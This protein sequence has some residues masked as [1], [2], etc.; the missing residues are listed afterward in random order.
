MPLIAFGWFS[1]P[2]VA[3]HVSRVDF[4]YDLS[5]CRTKTFAGETHYQAVQY[6]GR[7]A[8]QADSMASASGLVRRLDIDLRETPYLNGSWA[9]DRPFSNANEK[10]NVLEDIR[11]L[12]GASIDHI[13]AVAI[14]TGTDNSGRKAR[15]WY[16]G[17]YFSSD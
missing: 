3:M 14:T 13:E 11:N 5:T 12:T 8:L 16:G 7:A 6:R 1:G 4:P 15:A 10:R 17:L 9:V 2:A